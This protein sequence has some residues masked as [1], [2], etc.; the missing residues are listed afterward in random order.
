MADRFNELI[1]R[2]LEQP[3]ASRGV[4][5]Y[6]WAA[7][8]FHYMSGTGYTRITQSLKYHSDFGCGR[9]FAG[10]LAEK[11]ASAPE[12]SD[13]G[14]VIPVP[15]HWTRRWSR[16]FNQAEVIGGVLAERLGARL[17]TRIL[18]RVRR[19]RTQTKLGIEAKQTNVHGAFSADAG[20][21][22]VLVREITEVGRPHILLVDDVFTT[23]ATLHACWKA[24][25]D[26]FAST[27]LPADAVRIS[28]ATLASVVG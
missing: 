7:A 13:I 3:A 24:L 12:F 4:P 28:A 2:D 6:E 23:G 19:T 10:L 16:G 18:R 5:P 8:L 27:G 14:A 9:F 1:Q 21:L 25:D 26:A 22:S 20:R 17:S 15:L 11:L